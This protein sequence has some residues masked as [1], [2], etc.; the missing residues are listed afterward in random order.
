MVLTFAAGHLS[1]HGSWPAPRHARPMEPGPF[2]TTNHGGKPLPVT[3]HQ[4]GSLHPYR[5][6]GRLFRG[7][8]ARGSRNG[9]SRSLFNS[10]IAVG[11]QVPVALPAPRFPGYL[12]VH[13]FRRLR[14][15]KEN[16]AVA[17][18]RKA[19]HV[20]DLRVPG[21]AS[22]SDPDFGICRI[23]IHGLPVASQPQGDPGP[24]PFRQIV[25]EK[26]GR[27]ELVG[28]QQVGVAIV[29]EIRRGDPARVPEPIETGCVGDVTERSLLAPRSNS[30]GCRPSDP[31]RNGPR[32]R[33]GR[34]GNSR[35]SNHG[36]LRSGG[37]CGRR[38][39]RWL[40]RD[41]T[42]H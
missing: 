21:L 8:T 7:G 33:C 27:L 26:T 31:H 16:A 10:V 20:E 42:S 9:F 34:G 40:G 24:V 3:R 15:A 29:V 18:C 1:R 41:P 13:G 23:A 32:A 30:R 28:E 12:D 4:S 25:A 38:P 5:N 17:L 22:L 11:F 37:R 35:T 19:G 39:C 6:D 36:V 14:Q 2:P